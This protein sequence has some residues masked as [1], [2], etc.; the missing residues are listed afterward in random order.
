MFF[1]TGAAVAGQEAHYTYPF[2]IECSE[3]IVLAGE[4]VIINAKF[5]D[6]KTGEQYS[7]SYNWSISQGTI[8]SGQGTAS[9]IIRIDKEIIGSV[10]VRL[11]R[12][13][14]MAHFPGVQRSADCTIAIAPLP[15]PRMIDEFRTAGNNCEEG[16][17]RLDS[18]LAEINNNPVDEALIVFYGDN[19]DP[20]AA[21][22]REQQMRNHLTFR[23]FDR[24]RVRMFFGESRND[25]TTQFWLV[26]PGAEGP[27][28]S[29]VVPATGTVERPTETFLYATE[30]VDGIPGCNG[31]LYDLGAFS[32]VVKTDV[33]N[34]AKIVIG[35][36]TQARYRRKA[37]GIVDELRGHG[38]PSN[39]IVTVY[40][41]VRPNRM[42]E[43][44]ELSVIPPKRPVSSITEPGSHRC[45]QT[46]FFLDIGAIRGG[47]T[48]CSSL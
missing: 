17:A 18:F 37:K 45:P 24:N 19:R 40:K 8:E 46:G 43:F 26:P 33:A 14:H 47:A 27:A 15:E 13:F 30:Y 5:E 2:S 35:E 3:G 12:V 22:R 36:S 6:G 44:T 23:N 38:I 16:F 28:I 9:V 21:R 34:V 32:N 4:S 48:G 20:K 11:D 10:I 29:G 42:L 25:A 7:P 1:A 41:F 39:K 31:N